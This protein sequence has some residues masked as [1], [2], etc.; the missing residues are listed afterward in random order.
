MVRLLT[1]P[2]LMRAAFVLLAAGAAFVVAIWLMH[3]RLKTGA[4]ALGLS[5]KL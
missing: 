1:N 4:R 2:L 5:G 3:L